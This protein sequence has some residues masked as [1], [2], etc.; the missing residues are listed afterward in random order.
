M[1]LN[2]LKAQRAY[3]PYAQAASI[4]HPDYTI[5]F[6]RQWRCKELYHFFL[7]HNVGQDKLF[8]RIEIGG[9]NVRCRQYALKEKAAGLCYTAAP[10]S[11]T[12]LTLPTN[13][14]V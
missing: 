11:Y 9:H 12:H 4:Q 2:I 1:A 3:L 5:F 13:R 6:E 8:F 7:R 10:V 14:E